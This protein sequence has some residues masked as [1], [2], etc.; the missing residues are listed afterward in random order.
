MSYPTAKTVHT[1]CAPGTCTGNNR[2][3][4]RTN[5]HA[6]LKEI[7]NHL[8]NGQCNNVG[9]SFHATPHVEE[10]DTIDVP[11]CPEIVCDLTCYPEIPV[12][13]SDFPTCVSDIIAAVGEPGSTIFDDV[14]AAGELNAA[15]LT[16]INLMSDQSREY[17]PF[18]DTD[19]FELVIIFDDK[20]ALSYGELIDMGMNVRDTLKP[21]VFP[22]TFISFNFVLHSLV[23]D[24]YYQIFKVCEN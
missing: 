4:L 6:H 2:L 24:T 20:L 8:M 23:S 21:L 11:S 15:L 18:C 17:G 1:I 7:F 3:Q 16:L 19:T 22:T 5:N 13:T 10:L 14:E 12:V 9:R